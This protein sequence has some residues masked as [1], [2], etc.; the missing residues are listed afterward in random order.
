MKANKVFQ[1]MKEQEGKT[2]TIYLYGYIGQYGYEYDGHSQEG[3]QA[4]D[5]LKAVKELKDA[6][7]T[8]LNVRINSPGGNIMEGDGIMAAMK[9][10][11]ME[12]H[13]F[14]DGTAASYAF[15]LF[16]SAKKENRHIA[17]NGK[18]M[19]HDARSGVYGNAKALRTAADNLEVF[20]S[21]AIAQIVADTEMSIDDIKSKYFDGEDHWM[22]ANKAL[23]I[24]LVNQIDDYEAEATI[25][26]AEQMSHPQLVQF[27]AQTGKIEKNIFS[28]VMD[29]VRQQIGIIPNQK[30]E[31][32]NIETIKQALEKGEVTAEQL[33]TLT[34]APA[35]PTTTEV[36][37][38]PEL[39]TESVAQMI[40]A[41][42]TPVQAENAALKAENETL[43]K[44]PGAA[45]SQVAA[46]AGEPGE[47][48]LSPE[49]IALNTAAMADAK[50]ADEWRNPFSRRS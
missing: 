38:T 45:P 32:V 1:V 2:G 26:N 44:T 5:I 8:Q 34:A 15:A 27:F 22:D 37:P 25:P 10:S 43:K 18:L 36:P 35:P 14:C 49:M 33:A 20:N 11:K 46:P 48:A 17:Q 19:V 30:L 42:L 12:L 9:N 23:E 28:K 31:I 40:S 13:T 16:L 39:T 21:A 7:C 50:A 6:G 4:A 24:G 41:A 47:N 29:K 3:L